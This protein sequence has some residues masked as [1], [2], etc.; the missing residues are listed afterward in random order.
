MERSRDPLQRRVDSAAEAPCIL[1]KSLACGLDEPAASRLILQSRL[2][3][4]RSTNARGFL[5]SRR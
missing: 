2:P 5:P 3:R 1:S 4:H